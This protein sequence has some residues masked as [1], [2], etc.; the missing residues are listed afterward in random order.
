[1]RFGA[2]SVGALTLCGFA[3][4]ASFAQPQIQPAPSSDAASNV[5][6]EHVRQEQVRQEQVRQEEVRREHSSHRPAP[7][8]LS[9]D[10]GLSVIAAALDERVKA[11]RQPDC[12]HLVHAIYLQ[13][14]FPYPYASS[15]DLYAGAEDFQ[16]VTRPQPGDLVVWPGHVGI[17]VNPAQRAFFSR[18][19]RGPGI[20]AYDA[21]YWKQR[22]QVRFYRYVKTDPARVTTRLVN[23]QR[24]K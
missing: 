12:S 13:A 18:L 11:A 20:D 19:H 7:V 21:Q 4:S 3:L 22:G 10:D 2:K 8:V 9:P 17:V 24:H 6:Q 16:R 14:G 1:M 23:S 15:S 5:R